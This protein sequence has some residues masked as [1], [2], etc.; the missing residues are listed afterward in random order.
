MCS[1]ALYWGL[2][3]LLNLQLYR[4]PLGYC[5]TIIVCVRRQPTVTRACFDCAEL[6]RIWPV[7]ALRFSV[8]APNT[9]PDSQ[10]KEETNR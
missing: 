4:P 7:H 5:L 3:L 2:T 8:Y 10:V 9:C 1:L 6:H